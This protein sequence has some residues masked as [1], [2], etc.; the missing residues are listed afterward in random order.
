[1]EQRELRSVL[2]FLKSSQQGNI[3]TRGNKEYKKF[4]VNNFEY[5]YN[6]DKDI[7][8]KLKKK[9]EQVAKTQ[10]YKRYIILTKSARRVI[11][12]Q[13]LKNYASTKQQSLMKSVPSRTPTLTP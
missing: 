6:K 11:A 9:L 3:I 4:I 12:N 2:E 5:Q 13:Q 10:A 7:Q 8:G 1:M